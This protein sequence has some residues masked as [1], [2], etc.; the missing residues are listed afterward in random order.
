[1]HLLFSLRER[2]GEGT[3][4][5]GSTQTCVVANP[6]DTD[7]DGCVGM[8]DLLT[9]CQV[10]ALVLKCHGHGIR[11]IIRATIT[12]P[13]RLANSAG[14]LRTCVAEYENGDAIPAGLSNSEWDNTSSGALAVFAEDNSD[15]YNFSPDGDAR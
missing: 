15:Y 5:N 8:T 2:C 11:L 14:L 13:F 10:S 4:W 7:F 1:M 6:S 3:I 9:C 12:R